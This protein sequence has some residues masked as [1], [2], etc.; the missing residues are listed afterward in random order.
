MYKQ[1][2]TTPMVKKVIHYN[3]INDYI[4]MVCIV[5]IGIGYLY[6]VFK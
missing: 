6:M 2:K 5:L 3:P 1:Y 4:K